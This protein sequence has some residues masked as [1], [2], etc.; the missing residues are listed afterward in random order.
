MATLTLGWPNETPQKTDRLPLKAFVHS[1]TFHDYTTSQID[2]FYRYKEQLKE[3][4]PIKEALKHRPFRPKG[5]GYIEFI[6]K[7]K[8]RAALLSEKY[9]F[10]LLEE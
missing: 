4:R 2:D 10:D 1:E 6:Q 8:E 3:W 5:E 7:T 9:G